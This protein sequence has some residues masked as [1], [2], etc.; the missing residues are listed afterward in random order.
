MKFNNLLQNEELFKNANKALL[1]P[2]S[3]PITDENISFDGQVYKP[4]TSDYFYAV[5][6]LKVRIVLHFTAG[7]VRSDLQ[8]LT[9]NK[10]HVSTAF[11]V[12]RDGT[13]FNL[14]PSKFW[15]GHLGAGIGNANTGNAQDKATIGIEISN[16]GYLIPKEGNLETIYSRIYNEV[17][18]KNNP[19]DVYCS[20]SDTEAYTVISKPF[21]GQNHFATFTAAQIDNLII[22]L[23]FLT[24]KYSIPRDFLPLESRYKATN[25][26]LSFKGIVSHINYRESGKWDIGDAFPW[27]ELINGV[28]AV[29]YIPK[30]PSLRSFFSSFNSE[31][32]IEAS[33][34][35]ERGLFEISEEETTDNEGYDPFNFD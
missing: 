27:E 17:A 10:R 12:G 20:Q 35:Q 22:L 6:H 18:K 11:V 29:E 30:T 14:F 1:S 2:F 32:E 31:E 3:I 9:V 33:F 13:V 34:P 15:S 23:R 25:E 19:V 5:E 24:K 4:N 16:Y 8:S 26:V 28:K 7:N 21:R